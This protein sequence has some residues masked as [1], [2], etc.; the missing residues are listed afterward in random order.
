MRVGARL[1]HPEEAALAF[2]TFKECRRAELKME[3]EEIS[4]RKLPSAHPLKI[5]K[6][7]AAEAI[8]KRWEL[9]HRQLHRRRACGR[10]GC[11]VD[12]HRV[13]SGGR[14]GG[15]PRVTGA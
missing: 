8:F 10:S 5:A 14:A 11:G 12:C 2:A 13:G 7:G 4:S 1:N 6:G 9:L 3:K 15:C